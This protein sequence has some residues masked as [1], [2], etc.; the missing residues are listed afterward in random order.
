MFLVVVETKLYI[1]NLA[2]K[3]ECIPVGCVPP[4]AVA[5]CWGSASVHAGIHPWPDPQPPP[6]SGSR[7]P[8]PQPDP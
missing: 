8:L 1:E 3:Q 7:H 2:L 5:I 6:G 4:A